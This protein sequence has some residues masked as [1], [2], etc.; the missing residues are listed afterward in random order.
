MPDKDE[1]DVL[2]DSAL[3]TYA[4]P[5]PESGPESS[6]AQ[7]VLLSLAAAR[8][9]REGHSRSPKPR[10]WLAWAIAIPV[11]ASLLLWFSLTNFNALSTR[12]QQAAQSGSSPSSRDPQ[13]AT[14]THPPARSALKGRE[15][16]RVLK[17]HDLSRA[18]NA[19]HSRRV[20]AP[21]GISTNAQ[22]NRALPKL[23]VFPSPQPLTREEQ[24]LIAAIRGSETQRTALLE[25]AKSSSDAPLAIANLTIPPLVAP[26]EGNK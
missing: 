11:A 2:L 22:A 6:L 19:I 9:A 18:E 8:A 21:E 17:G 16:G 10:R 13:V 3:S 20:L 24:V 7:R 1:L 15:V 25:A 5:G 12:Q 26:D 14:D 23:A 4:D